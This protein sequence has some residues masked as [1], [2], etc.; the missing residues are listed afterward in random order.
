MR[1]TSD[2]LFGPD[3]REKMSRLFQILSRIYSV[4]FLSRRLSFYGGTALHS[5]HFDMTERLSIDLDFNFRQI[6]DVDWGEQRDEVDS[7]IRSILES[8]DYPD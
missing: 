2:N 6:S 1:R 3:V 7:R 5:I 4:D 8:L